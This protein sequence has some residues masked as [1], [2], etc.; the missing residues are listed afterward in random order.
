MTSKPVNGGNV[1]RGSSL[2]TIRTRVDRLVTAWPSSPETTFVHWV[3]PYEQC[4]SCTADLAAYAQAAALAQAVEGHAPG[5]RPPRLVFYDALT[6]CPRKP[7][8]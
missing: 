4:P 6:T 5:A 7:A 3:H 8:G 2:S 1:M